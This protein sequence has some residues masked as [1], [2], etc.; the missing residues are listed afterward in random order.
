MKLQ[1]GLE[2]MELGTGGQTKRPLQT[3]VDKSGCLGGQPLLFNLTT[4]LWETRPGCAYLGFLPV[5]GTGMA[6]EGT[7]GEVWLLSGTEDLM[8]EKPFDQ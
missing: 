7:A 3:H 8:V 5:P 1:Y 2:G 4:S 6:A